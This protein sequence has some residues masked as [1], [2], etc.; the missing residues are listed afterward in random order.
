M[1]TEIKS[2]SSFPF[3]Y[4]IKTLINLKMYNKKSYPHQTGSIPALVNNYFPVFSESPCPY[5]KKSL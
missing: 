2:G 3:I 5:G 4:V 1:F